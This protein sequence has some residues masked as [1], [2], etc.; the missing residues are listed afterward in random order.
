MSEPFKV[1]VADKLAA[2]GLDVFKAAGASIAADV[3]VGLKPDELSAVIGAYDALAVRSATQVTA[4]IIEAG[5]RLKV[6]GR[7]G[8]GVDNIDVP[9]ATKRGITVMNTPEGNI[10]TTAEHALSL[11]MSLARRVPQATASM[12]QGKWEK[13]KFQGRELANKTLGV[14]GLGNI[15]KIVAHRAQGLMMQ[16]IALDPYVTPE[17]AK[18][19]GVALVSLDELLQKSD[20]VTLHVPLVEATKNIIS[21]QAI[22]RMKKG[23]YLINAARGGL[24]DE[25]AAADALKS[26]KLAGAAFDV[27]VEEP[28]PKDHPLLL[29]ENVIVTPHLGASTD[30][31]QI[32]VSIQVAEQI[33]D[34]LTKGV[35]KSAVNAPTLAKEHVEAVGP[36][37]RLARKMGAFAAQL[38]KGG[39]RK[40]RVGFQGAAAELPI[41]PVSVAM[42]TGLLRTQL[43]Q[44]VNE[45]NAPVVAK[46]RGIDVGD[47]RSS[48][49]RDFA[50]AISIRVAGD[51]AETE[52]VGTLFGSDES[53]IVMVNGVRLEIVPEG[54]ILMTRHRDRP[55]IIGKI[56]TV[57]G[58]HQVNISRLVLG[59]A[60]DAAEKAQAVLS[61]DGAVAD[62][63]L[64]ELS[65]IDG[66]ESVRHL[67]LG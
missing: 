64:R 5:K 38:H 34:F 17:R 4:Q 13:S 40:V 67:D 14:V 50:G 44:E 48:T 27:F 2:E 22:E 54:H 15:G 21:R 31:A 65:T 20:F 6:I 57:L 7:A 9:A 23:A 37:V 28:P 60:K 19:L 33:V 58:K 30:E 18:E 39:V 8:I 10:V 24:V 62:D 42:L 66:I 32:N 26:G 36:Y 52:V 56:G 25:A 12:R 61:V 29:L 53:R 41:A 16:V 1:L 11:L 51:E 47:F 3:K 43:G 35:V 59:L 49:S 55:G 63:V 46:E 45:V